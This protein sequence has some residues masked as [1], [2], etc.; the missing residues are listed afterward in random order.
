[1]VCRFSSSRT[2]CEKSNFHEIDIPLL[3]AILTVIVL[4]GET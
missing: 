3:I 1:M 2:E 4:E